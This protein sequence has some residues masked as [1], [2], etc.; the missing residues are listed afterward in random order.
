[1]IDYLGQTEDA[2]SKDLLSHGYEATNVTMDGDDYAGYRSA[3]EVIIFEIGK[4]GTVRQ[5]VSFNETEATSSAQL[6]DEFS[7][8]SALIKASYPSSQSTFLGQLNKGNEPYDNETDFLNKIKDTKFS[9]ITFVTGA[10]PI[11][12]KRKDLGGVYT[13]RVLTVGSG[14]EAKYTGIGF[15]TLS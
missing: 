13:L 15:M 4:M 10:L 11:S 8:L 6:V 14:D 3:G 9:T 7:V 5:I 2:V 1:M 12:Y